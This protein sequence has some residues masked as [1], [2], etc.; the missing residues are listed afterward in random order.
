M[1]SIFSEFTNLYPVSKTL[2]FSLEP[3]GSTLENIK[4]WGI[5]EEDQAKADNYKIVKTIFDKCHKAYI[6]SVLDSLS[7][8][9]SILAE[10]FFKYQKE[11]N[12]ENKNVFEEV[13]KAMMKT[14]SKTLKGN[15]NYKKLEPNQLVVD[16]KN[17]LSGK[18]FCNTLIGELND[19]ELKAVVRFDGFTT[20]FEGY[21]ETRNN[22]YS[23]N[24]S[25]SIA[26]RLIEENFPKFLNNIL[27]F[28]KLDDN[29]KKVLDANLLT[30][31]S[32]ESLAEIFEINYFNNILNQR[33]ID[34][35]N[36]FFEGNTEEGN[37]KRQGLNELCNIAYQQGDLKNKVK[38]N[39]LF[40]QILSERDS[41][42]FVF[43]KFETDIQ[44]LSS[45][46]AYT[47]ILFSESVQRH[48][49]NFKQTLS[50][51]NFDKTAVFVDNKRIAELSLLAFGEWDTLRVAMKQNKIKKEGAYN[52]EV[53]QSVVSE[54]LSIEFLKAVELAERELTTAKDK[55]L[56]E[57]CCEKIKTY[58]TI[59]AYLDSIVKIEGLLK[60]F[61]VSDIYEK[62]AAFYGDFDAFYGVLRNNIT[63]YNQVRNYATKKE[64]SETKISLNFGFGN[65]LNGW[66]DSKT[67][68]SDNGTQY[69]GF[70]FRKDNGNGFDYYLGICKK[71]KAL[72]EATNEEISEYERLYYYQL[73][74]QSFLGSSYCG[75]NSYKD[76]KKE[77]I[78]IIKDIAKKNN[79][80][81]FDK[82]DFEQ[83]TP[84]QL[85]NIFRKNCAD[86]K[87]FL[88]NP[89]FNDKNSEIISNLIKTLET[90]VEKI[91]IVKDYI[92]KQYTYCA[93]L[94]N[95]IDEICK[96]KSRKFIK[97][98]KN[99]FDNL[100]IDSSKPL[101]LFKITN[102]DFDKK[103]TN[104]KK[105]I[106]N[107]HTLYFKELL[108]GSKAFDLGT[109]AMFFRKASIENPFVHEKGE[110]VVNK[111]YEVDGIKHS[112]P[113]VCYVELTDYYN[114]KRSVDELSN[115]TKNYLP[116][117]KYH[118]TQNRLVK[119]KRYTKDKFLFHLS[120]FLS[121][122]SKNLKMSELNTR[123]LDILKDNPDV[124]IIG[125]DRGERN[126]IY[127]SLID[128][129]G[130][131]KEQKS[132]NIINGVDYL[133]KLI[134][135]SKERD[136]ARKN[137]KEIG[138]IK[139][140][141][142]GYLSLVIH[143][144]TDMMLKHN[145]ILVLEDLNSHFKRGRCHIEQQ[146]YQK[147]EKMLIDK[148]NYLA[149]KNKKAL[150]KGGISC[151]YQLTGKFKSFKSIG[152]QNGFLFY[153]PA[154]WTSK[155]DP[156][157]G[158]VNLFTNEQLKF[159]NRDKAKAFI[160]KFKRIEYNAAE[161]YF[162]FDFKYS[163]FKLNT[164]D[165]T[166][167]WT[168]CTHGKERISYSK[169]N[170]YIKIDVTEQLKQL[171]NEYGIDYANGSLKDDICNCDNASF[172][173]KLLWLFKLTVTLR[174]EDSRE[175]YI[176]SP[177]KNSEGYFFDSRKATKNDPIDGDAN[178]AYHIALQGLRIVKKRIDNG[179]IIKDEKEKQTYNWL[180]FVQEKE[181]LN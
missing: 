79:L 23:D 56:P 173:K 84:N 145:A 125:I 62:D 44:L 6:N 81:C 159:V 15:E 69:G 46:K 161:D 171:F 162:E 99:E 58:D 137:W 110:I 147:F 120:T 8:D 29:F 127:V 32:V 131:I 72:R 177:I 20:Y 4:K 52:F 141:K 28:K 156:K 17:K 148:L 26:H 133:Q 106:E 95:D 158:F 121:P 153:V 88:Q 24:G 50:S 60:I 71:S 134:I 168:V 140:L 126:L 92:N 80:V 135:I 122:S 170:G 76:D 59:K 132:F 165:Y 64:Y 73:K 54:N 86:E 174:H 176:L 82:I 105:S 61:S 163:D 129:Y 43:D 124:N 37:I 51:G 89:K 175:D 118:K 154:R 94:I 66:V 111:M 7:F 14:V 151:A 33:G 13:K 130:N 178:G 5:L 172:M 139:D 109:G 116:I 160:D 68:K 104:G 150:E 128:R 117:A 47:D 21:Q 152:T 27:L 181:Y 83:T 36:R 103:N 16:A 65:F 48:F 112:I 113:G 146:V 35:Y 3:Q 45:V 75:A 19:E 91:P 25:T 87:L 42:S 100:L 74:S 102:K 115:D 85:I 18:P 107:L 114:D 22:I 78:N 9:W 93:D 55:V 142:E 155:I 34:I 149:D 1:N 138:K 166:D 40:K 53:I 167:T 90:F 49:S 143:E 70:I 179:H 108:G 144:I 12:E 123:V 77:L 31:S 180:K 169:E 57:L 10:A 96:Y 101:F 164:T 98:S 157:T 119:D 2:R 41:A 136:N 97:I 38:F 67:E 39:I 30:F 11:K 63:L